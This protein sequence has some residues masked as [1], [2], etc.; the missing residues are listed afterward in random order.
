VQK[1][2]KVANWN[3][4]RVI[5][6]EK[7]SSAI[8][9][10]ISA[11]GAD[12]WVL[13]E[14]HEEVGLGEKFSSC[15][16]GQPDRPS[17]MGER[18]IGLFSRWTM[19][20]LSKFVSD[21]SR[22]AAGHITESPFGEL[23]LYGTVLP[24]TN[25]WR[26]IPAQNGQAF[27]AALSEQCDDW[28]RIAKHFPD[29]TFILAGDFNQDLALNHYYGSKRKRSMLE[30]ALRKADLIPLTAGVSDP[31]ARD[32]APNACI[33]HIFISASKGWTSIDTQR[34]PNS[35]TPVGSLSDHFG[36]SVDLMRSSRGIKV[37]AL[38]SVPDTYV[39]EEE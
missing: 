7:R 30:G 22:C 31:I 5:P 21:S 27:G 29:A 23:V 20:S 35:P 16:S 13:S 12:L 32:S 37:P 10:H 8:K 28:Q 3:I 34:W 39:S 6:P 33:D 19:T 25:A 24:W 4:E 14:T 15:F 11:V 38:N 17:Q 26:G 1:S 2:L 36:V 18:W 9:E